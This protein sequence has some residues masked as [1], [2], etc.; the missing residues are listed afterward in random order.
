MGQ[1]GEELKALVEAAREGDDVAVRELVRRTQPVIWRLCSALGSDGEAD[2]LVQDT[3]LR[4]L[5]SLSSYRGDGPVLAW[6]SA[7]ARRV[8]ADHVRG[9]V[10]HRRL[11]GALTQG[12][13][14]RWESAPGNPTGE[15]LRGIDPD[16]RD[17]FMLT[18]VA[19]LSYEEAAMVLDCPIG[20]IRSRVARARVDL[21]AEVRAAEAS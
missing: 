2:D 15:L 21:L 9:R 18:Q 10:R 13:D 8:C 7:I 3:Y 6:L 12:L 1:N 17:A 16:R 19:G 14:E 4:A 20:T 11:I 5:R